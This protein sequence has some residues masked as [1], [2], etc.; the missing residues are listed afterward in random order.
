M[1]ISLTMLLLLLN[2]SCSH[3][4]AS[5]LD[6][7]LTEKN[8]TPETRSKLE[9]IIKEQS[10]TGKIVIFDFD[11]TLIC[12]DIGEATLGILADQ[13]KINKM[14]LHELISPGIKN[15]NPT[16]Y[17][18]QLLSSTEHHKY[19]KTA[20]AN[21][22]AWAVQAMAGLSP[23]DIINATEKAFKDGS[24]TSDI[25]L[26]QVSEINVKNKENRFAQPYFYPEMVEL[27]SKF[28]ENDYQIYVVSASNVWTVRWMVNQLN[29]QI[30]KEELTKDLSSKCLRSIDPF[31]RQK[32]KTIQRPTSYP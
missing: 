15:D 30:E 10:G 8:W 13:N 4:G 18:D 2:L 12:R 27:V 14:L 21:G 23:V 24:A 26:N 29:N 7:S 20:H 31:S 1:R 6:V 3:L 16:K 22:Y 25:E 17:Y 9:T 11:N 28:L 5:K 19:E 32:W